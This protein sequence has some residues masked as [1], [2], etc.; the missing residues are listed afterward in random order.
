MADL[1]NNR[2]IDNNMTEGNVFKALLY[3]TIPLIISGFLQQLYT[4]ADSVIVGNLVSETALA[5]VGVSAPVLNVFIYVITGLVSGYTI[6]ISQ[7][8]GAKDYNKVLKLTST[9]FIFITLFSCF[10]AAIGFIFNNKILISLNTP[11]EILQPAIDY[12]T[13]I[14]IGVPFVVLYN[15]YSSLLRGIGNSKTPLY[16]IILSSAINIV[17]DL[18]FIYNFGWGIKGAAVAT[19]ISQ[20]IS[21]IYLCFYVNRYYPMF[22]VDVKIDSTGL[23][24]FFES[25]RLSLPRVIQSAIG[26]VGGLLL[27]NIMNSFGFD[28]VTA[29]T[30][31]YK[32]D[33]LTILP[34]INISI[35]ISIFVGQN[36]GAENMDR[37]K[38]GLKKGIIIILIVSVAVTTIVVSA[39]FYLM[40]FF[41]VSNEVAQIGQNFFYICGIF[42]PV[43][44]LENAYSSFLQGNK[45]VAFTS[46]VSIMSLA[47][48]L[49]LS[50]ALASLIGYRVI[51]VAEMCTWVFAAIVFY[52]RYKSDGWKKYSMS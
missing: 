31:A 42:Y 19:V 8:Y 9:F 41:G 32:I 5:A 16:S 27:Q 50:Y 49:I 12:L 24:L 15:L 2:K 48:R 36:V 34:I 45:D 3:F 38:E 18:V 33:T 4:I 10:L 22:K 26:S 1:N 17:L 35:A 29:I 39:G 14:F 46:I 40:K 43:F 20:V 37:A 28:V 25:L 21:S 6:L 47:L 23:N 13:I 51:A 52:A 44:G 7:Y 11:V 30:T